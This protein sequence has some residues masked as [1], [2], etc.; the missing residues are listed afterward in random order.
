MFVILL[1]IY[2]LRGR[3]E[4][5][6]VI[7][8]QQ[9]V[10]T[11]VHRS[12]RVTAQMYIWWSKYIQ[13]SEVEKKKTSKFIDYFS[14]ITHIVGKKSPRKEKC[15]RDK[16]TVSEQAQA[17]VPLVGALTV[18]GPEINTEKKNTENSGSVIERQ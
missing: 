8:S 5:L 2:W 10:S 13:N 9:C 16:K 7:D 17:K 1:S 18:F 11:T 12:S 3:E 6:I 4:F 15:V 14:L